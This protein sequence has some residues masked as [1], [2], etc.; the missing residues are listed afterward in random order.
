MLMRGHGTRRIIT[1]IID[2]HA[3]Y[4]TAPPELR[5]DILFQAE[6]IAVL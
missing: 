6:I 4:T 2:A 1:M 3:H 5:G